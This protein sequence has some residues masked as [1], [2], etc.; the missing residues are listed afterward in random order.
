M[1]SLFPGQGGGW[2]WIA[3]GLANSSVASLKTDGGAILARL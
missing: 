2:R 3:V 1:G